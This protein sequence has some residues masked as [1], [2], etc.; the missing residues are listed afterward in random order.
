MNCF[1]VI[2]NQDN[3]SKLWK[4]Y[5]HTLPDDVKEEWNKL[6]TP[7]GDVPG[8]KQ[9][10]K[11][12][13]VNAH[14]KRDADWGDELAIKANTVKAI[15]TGKDTKAKAAIAMGMTRTECEAKLPGDSIHILIYRFRLFKFFIFMISP[16]SISTRLNSSQASE[17]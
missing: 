4:K 6:M 8:G 9:N 16:R 2:K 5:F 14:V 10:K 11:N 17:L 7:G 15:T 1:T 13:L 12:E 3:G